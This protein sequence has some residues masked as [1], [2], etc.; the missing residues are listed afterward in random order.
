MAGLWFLGLRK[1]IK[2]PVQVV[3]QNVH[4]AELGGTGLEA[5]G[6]RG[7]VGGGVS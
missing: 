2:E 5:T 7:T 1:S 3:G 4:C 6:T